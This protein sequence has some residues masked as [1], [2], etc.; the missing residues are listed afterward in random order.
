MP[1]P[2]SLSFFWPH[3]NVPLRQVKSLVRK[4]R[5]AFTLIELLVVLAVI[6]LLAALLFPAVQFAREAAR[7]TSCKSNLRQI[8]LAT[9]M[10]HDTFKTL[11]PGW[12]ANDPV[13]GWPDPE[14]EPG[15]GW[16]ARILPFLEQTNLVDR[17]DFGRPIGDAANE[18]ARATVLPI[19]LCSS[20]A[21]D[22]MWTLRDE[23]SGGPLFRLAK[24]NYVGVFGTFD[25]E[26]DPAAGE[27]VL[28][29]NSK[30]R[31]AD[32]KD[33]LSMTFLVGERSSFIG[34][35]T[36]TGVIPDG[37][38]AMDRILGIC[39]LPPNPK[40]TDYS[41]DG[42]MDDF[43]SYHVTG[44]QFLFA[45]GAVRWISQQINTDVYRA[46]ATRARRDI[47]GQY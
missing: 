1:T 44:T 13:S 37:E 6:G 19:Y 27:G 32:I 43:S 3:R 25:I 16:A 40:P 2:C 34:Y 31:F 11:P 12:L 21:G 46:L 7:R 35:S 17:L 23:D 45:D 26:D 4:R 38:E 10:Y 42:E 30:V 24:S 14:G 39:D 5:T 33:G 15:W 47:V 22:D 28:F 8:G 41:E 29:H 36:W 20:D 18:V 9:Q